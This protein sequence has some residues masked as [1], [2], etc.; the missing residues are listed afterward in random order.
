MKE[1]CLKILVV[2]YGSIGKR[3]IKNLSTLSNIQIIV[4]TNRKFDSFLQKK[5]SFVSNNIQ[6]CISQHPDA[7]IIANESNLHVEHSIKLAKKGIHLFIEKPLS[8]S[9]DKI[10][11]LKSLVEQKNLITFLGCNFRFHSCI[12]KIKEMLDNGEIGFVHSVRV[13]SSSF[14]PDWH[15]NEDYSKSYAANKTLGGGV[16]LSCIHEIDYLYWFFG[17]VK[18]VFSK[19]GKHSNLNIDVE[20]L[21]S[22]VIQFKNNVIAELH[23]DFLQ[24]PNFRS[25]KI[26]GTKGV[27]YWDS[28][29]NIVKIYDPEKK[30]WQIK[31][32]DV[33]YD[34]NSMYVDELS[35]F[36][37]CIKTKN[38]TINDLSQGI[39]T[40][41]I[42][43]AILKSSQNNM[44][45]S[46]E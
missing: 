26:I 38:N 19:S 16:V 36:V 43:L 35:H 18:E 28:D 24:R 21:S 22:S 4:Y 8:H 44:V 17:S 25:C 6:D 3:H 10:N 2:G 23:L 42:A 45:I 32:E 31:F 40:L 5:C 34:R 37:N 30:E 14:L 41:E 33:N 11:E 9:M 15:P 20:D 12:K 7:A 46:L 13:E 27:I 39:E 29:S 1:K